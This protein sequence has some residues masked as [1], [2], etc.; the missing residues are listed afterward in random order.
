[1]IFFAPRLSKCHNH[2][3]HI[4][5]L[6]PVNLALPQRFF[7][8]NQMFGNTT[9]DITFHSAINL[10]I[11]QFEINQHNSSNVLVANQ[12]TSEFV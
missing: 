6:H 2:K 5:T 1:M 11:P 8:D 4:P 7:N 12:S 3:D 10:T 9:A